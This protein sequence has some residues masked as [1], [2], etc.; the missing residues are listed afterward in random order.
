VKLIED[1]GARER[2]AAEADRQ[3][4][5]ALASLNRILIPAETR[6]DLAEVARFVTER[7][8]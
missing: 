2:T 3:A 6:E 7:E 4:E 8:L 5:L 1:S